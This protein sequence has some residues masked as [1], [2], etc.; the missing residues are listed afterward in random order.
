MIQ[1]SD[2]ERPSPLSFPGAAGGEVSAATFGKF[3][4]AKR[5][6]FQSLLQKVRP[7][8][9]LGLVFLPVFSSFSAGMRTSWVWVVMVA[10]AKRMASPPWRSM[11]SL[12][13]T[14]LP[15]DLD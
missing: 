2:K 4:N 1:R 12:G 8:S 7:L 10:S 5:A 15:R 14:P 6:A 11:M 3:D 9:N 13:S